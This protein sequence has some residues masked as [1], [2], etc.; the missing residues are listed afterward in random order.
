VLRKDTGEGFEEIAKAAYYFTG[1]LYDWLGTVRREQLGVG[2]SICSVFVRKAL[3]SVG[4]P[5]AVLSD[6]KPQITPAELYGALVRAGYQKLE[7]GYDFNRWKKDIG[8]VS[9]GAY[10]IFDVLD[11]S[12][13]SDKQ[14][15]CFNKSLRRSWKV[16]DKRLDRD[17][18]AKPDLMR[19]VAFSV[20]RN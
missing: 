19:L 7:H 10:D 20:L 2:K 18:Y 5:A 1:E 14:L 15:S 13:I 16:L 8:D 11:A 6:Y 12:R 3:L 4:E 9:I 17:L